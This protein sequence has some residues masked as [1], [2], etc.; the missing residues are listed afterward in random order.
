MRRSNGGET[1]PLAG[2][3]GGADLTAAGAARRLREAFENW[4]GWP[5]RRHVLAILVLAA[6]ALLR[7]GA[8]VLEREPLVDEKFYLAAFELAAEGE[9]PYA[10]SGFYYP[11]AFAHGGGFLLDSLGESGVVA[12]LRGLNLLSLGFVVWVATAWLGTSLGS[13]PW[14][15]GLA[16]GAAVIC[17]APGAWLGLLLGNLSFLAMAPVL[18]ALLAWRPRPIG[19][20]LMLGASLAVKPLAPVA[21]LALIA[22]R[23]AED[24]DQSV[25]VRHRLAAAVAGVA[26]ALLLLLPRGLDQ[27]LS[28]PVEELTRARIVSLHR[29][30]GHIGLAVDPIWVAGLVAVAVVVTVRVAGPLGRSQLLFVATAGAALATPLLWNHT[31][32]MTLPLQAAAL[33]LAMERLR[34]APAERRRR[35][36]YDL[37]FVLLAVAALLFVNGGGVDDRAQALQA[38]VVVVPSL[39]PAALAAYVLA[40]ADPF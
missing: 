9:S 1:I 2:R 6:I 10:K 29:A 39:A 33:H 15:R 8:A 17:L 20:G 24:G 22:H 12:L 23:P 37:A 3:G 14:W 4:A 26:G 34:A 21:I 40:V 36:R 32:L 5:L 7:H 25:G 30:L 18:G 27:M 35:R 11:P 16:A 28:Q 13:R 31:L 38:L 19:A